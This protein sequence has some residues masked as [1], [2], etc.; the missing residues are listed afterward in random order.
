[1]QEHT[2]QR[3]KEKEK[4]HNRHPSCDAFPLF[5]ISKGM[6]C[7][8]SSLGPSSIMSTIQ[9]NTRSVPSLETERRRE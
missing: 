6:E 7:R 5:G 1:M 4:R 8:A 3:E 2:E 9:V